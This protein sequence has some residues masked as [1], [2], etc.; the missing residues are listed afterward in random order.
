MKN[1]ILIAEDHNLLRQGHRLVA[2]RQPLVRVA[3][4]PQC[5]S[6]KD[7]A[8]HASI[9][10]VEEGRGAVL[11]GIVEGYTLCKVRV[12]SSWLSHEE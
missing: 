11:L 5:P 9:A 1:R 3:K 10:P 7:T 12:R 6:A 8:N 4:I 2:P